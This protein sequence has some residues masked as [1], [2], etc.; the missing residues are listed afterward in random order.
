MLLHK[1]P[2]V[3]ENGTIHF[4]GESLN[5]AEAIKLAYRLTQAVEDSI[6]RNQKGQPWFYSSERIAERC[7]SPLGKAKSHLAAVYAIPFYEGKVVDNRPVEI[8]DRE[9]ACGGHESTSG[10]IGNVTFCDGSCQD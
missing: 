1:A 9:A 4:G 7:D 5:Q 10:P 6:W 8:S 3:D 2:E